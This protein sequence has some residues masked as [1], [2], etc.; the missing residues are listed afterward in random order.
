VLPIGANVLTLI[1]IVLIYLIVNIR[2]AC[3]AWLNR[4]DRD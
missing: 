1:L 4:P 3:V 2:I